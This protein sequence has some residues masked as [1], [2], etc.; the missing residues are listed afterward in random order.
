[1]TDDTSITNGRDKQTNDA[2]SYHLSNLQFIINKK[3][4]IIDISD[5]FC[6]RVGR[7]KEDL[8]GMSLEDTG[9]LTEESRKTFMVRNVSRLVGKEKP[10]FNLDV[11]TMDGAVLS[12]EIDAKPFVKQGKVIGEI[13]I[14]RRIIAPTQSIKVSEEQPGQ[15]QVRGTPAEPRPDSEKITRE[16]QERNN[17]N[18]SEFDSLQN[19]LHKNELRRMNDR[20]H[21][22]MA[23]IEEKTYEIQ[24][25]QEELQR[26]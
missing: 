2:F 17:H 1:M 24:R 6:S 13:G 10:F 21:K 14:V 19:D 7:Q 15:R 18:E 22:N 20:L 16:H 8:I 26:T 23:D 25:L 11:K 9:L 12:L 3:G 4:E 5:A